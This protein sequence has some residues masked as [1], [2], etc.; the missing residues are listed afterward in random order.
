MVCVDSVWEECIVRGDV[1]LFVAHAGVGTGHPLL[2]VHGGPD[3][4]HSYLREPLVRLCGGR[5]LLLPDLRGCGRSARGLPLTRYHPDAVI[6]D[7]LEILDAFG[8]IAADVLGFS[9]G[10]LLAQRLAV[11]APE[12]IHRL[13]IA[14][15]SVLPVPAD[16]F[17]GWRERQERRAPELEIWARSVLGPERTRAAAVAGA[18]ANVWRPA[19]L[20]DYLRRLD[21]V[22]FS[23]EWD[24]AR[25][26][27]TL[28]SPRVDDPIRSGGCRRPRCR[29]FCCTAAKT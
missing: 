5:R 6:A 8:I 24:R 21:A 23:A 13:I 1:E 11:T 16:A 19:A 3:W 14:S 27:G 20:P 25:S 22:R 26:A 7:L 12:R 9:H 17:A 18:R 2:V 15:S 28:R 29:Y 10:G 4:D